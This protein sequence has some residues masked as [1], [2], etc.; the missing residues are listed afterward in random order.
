MDLIW[1]IKYNSKL[2]WPKKIW[3]EKNNVHGL[4]IEFSLLNIDD[5]ETFSLHNDDDHHLHH[6]MILMKRFKIDNDDGGYLIYFLK[7]KFPKKKINYQIAKYGR[8][9]YFNH[10]VYLAL[11]TYLY[12]SIKKN[13][14]THCPEIELDFHK[15]IHHYW[16]WWWWLYEWSIFGNKKFLVFYLFKILV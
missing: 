6:Q 3:N 16:W 9:V 5:D 14:Q 15:C 10:P 7:P 8:K 2:N 4:K 12:L 11:I 1:K 13:T